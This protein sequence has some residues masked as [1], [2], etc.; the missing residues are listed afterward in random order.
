MFVFY[1]PHLRNSII[2]S[3]F[4]INIYKTTRKTYKCKTIQMKKYIY[5]RACMLRLN[6]KKHINYIFALCANCLYTK[7]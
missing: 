1:T 4:N 6:R 2:F 5:I 7:F 3:L